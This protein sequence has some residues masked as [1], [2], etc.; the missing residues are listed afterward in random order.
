MLFLLY[1]ITTKEDITNEQG[2]IIN[3]AVNDSR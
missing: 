3:C 2:T 1:I